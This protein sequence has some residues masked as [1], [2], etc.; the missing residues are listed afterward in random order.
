MNPQ[1]ASSLAEKELIA[2]IEAFRS[3]SGME[4][5]IK[6]F[7]PTASHGSMLSLLPERHG[8]HLSPFCLEVKRTRT[9]A[10][11]QCDLRDVLT[12][13]EREK[14]IFVNTCHAGACEMILPLFVE[15]SLAGVCY[16]GQFRVDRQG[17][18]EL[19]RLAPAEKVRFEGLAALLRSYLTEHIRSPRFPSETSDSYRGELIWNFMRG[20][21]KKNPGLPDLAK[22]LGISVS[23]ASHLLRET[24]GVSFTAL[25]DALRIEHA[26]ELLTHSYYKV[27]HVA[28]ECGFDD[29]HYFHRFFRKQIGMTPAQF[30]RTKFSDMPT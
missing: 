14:K 4:V 21:L 26:R 30:R 11:R 13:C 24:T 8:L 20:R 16:L 12:R 22:H 5:V 25:R 17:P 3:V 29:S 15:E 2:A 19:R 10:C 28:A 1:I 18:Q 23:R 9:G 7:H 27:A 6:T